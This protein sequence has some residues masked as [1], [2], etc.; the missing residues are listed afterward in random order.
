MCF[1]AEI[2][3][4]LSYVEDLHL[5]LGS[6]AFFPSLIPFLLYSIDL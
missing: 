1:F 4:K 3:S 2:T 5:L 6:L